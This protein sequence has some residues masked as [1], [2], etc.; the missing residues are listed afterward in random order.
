MNT[1]QKYAFFYYLYTNIFIYKC[2]VHI[3]FDILKID[4]YKN[5]DK[6]K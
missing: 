5:M 2:T 6:S 4:V 3:N 1:N